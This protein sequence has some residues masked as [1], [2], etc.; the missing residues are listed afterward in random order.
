MKTNI[1]FLKE[2]VNKLK[3]LLDDPEPGIFTWQSLVREHIKWISDFH[4]GKIEN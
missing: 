3:M 2:H 4:E 1:E